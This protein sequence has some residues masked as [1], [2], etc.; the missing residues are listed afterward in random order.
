MENNLFIAELFLSTEVKVKIPKRWFSDALAVLIP[1]VEWAHKGREAGR[2]AVA[3]EG[4]CLG[5][6]VNSWVT[7][8]VTLCSARQSEE[9]LSQAKAWR[10][11]ETIMRVKCPLNC[12]TRT[13]ASGNRESWRLNGVRV[14]K[15]RKKEPEIDDLIQNSLKFW[16]SSVMASLDVSRPLTGWKASPYELSLASP[17]VG[18]LR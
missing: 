12:F 17:N 18:S 14:T 6:G 8:L 15:T 10:N 3:A 5:R 7:A 16:A 4:S 2:T 1:T 11:A 9:W 13:A